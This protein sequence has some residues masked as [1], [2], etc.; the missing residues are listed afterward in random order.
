MRALGAALVL[1]G[2]SAAV[3]AIRA[4]ATRGRP[5]DLVAALVAPIAIPA[6]LAGGVL[7]L[8]PGFLG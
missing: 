1:A 3:F 2:G 7:L 5:G 6:A 8:V 4:V